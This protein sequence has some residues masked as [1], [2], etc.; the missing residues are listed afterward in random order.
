MTGSRPTRTT[1]NARQRTEPDDQCPS[2]VSKSSTVGRSDS[3]IGVPAGAK[4]P[5]LALTLRRQALGPISEGFGDGAEFL[6]N[7]AGQ[8]YDAGICPWTG[9]L[10]PSLAGSSVLETGPGEPLAGARAARA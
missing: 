8:D 5:L 6:R 9:K 2:A 7:L 1:T 10:V 3:A 4:G